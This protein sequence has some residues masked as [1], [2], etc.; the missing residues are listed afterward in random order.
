MK[1]AGVALTGLAFPTVDEACANAIAKWKPAAPLTSP[2]QAALPQRVHRIIQIIFSAFAAGESFRRA[3]Y[4]RAATRRWA[5]CAAA[6]APAW[7]QSMLRA[8]AVTSYTRRPESN[9][10]CRMALPCSAAL[11]L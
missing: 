1:A 3:A 10:N 7:Q 4:A 11:H 5:H 6:S 2:G 9:P 8:S